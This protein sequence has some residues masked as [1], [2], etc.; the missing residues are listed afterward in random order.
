MYQGAAPEES[1]WSEMQLYGYLAS[2]L[3]SQNDASDALVEAD[4]KGTATRTIQYP[5]ENV[6]I[7]FSPVIQPQVE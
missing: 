3:A 6:R 7:V 2:H 5:M 4:Q 1:D